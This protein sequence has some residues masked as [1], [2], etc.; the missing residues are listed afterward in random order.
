[1]SIAYACG[2]IKDFGSIVPRDNLSNFVAMQEVPKNGSFCR[3]AGCIGGFC[4]PCLKLYVQVTGR[5]HR[6]SGKVA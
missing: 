2:Q 3:G 6:L 4:E 1:M 5:V